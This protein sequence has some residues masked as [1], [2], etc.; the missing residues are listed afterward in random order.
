MTCNPLAMLDALL[1]DEKHRTSI[2]I[3]LFTH[4]EYEELSEKWKLSKDRIPNRGNMEEYLVDKEG[5]RAFVTPYV[6]MFSPIQMGTYGPASKTQGLASE[7]V[8][9]MA[10]AFVKLNQGHTRKEILETKMKSDLF[11]TNQDMYEIASKF[12]HV[13]WIHAT[14]KDNLYDIV[15]SGVL[16]C[17]LA[18]KDYR[19]PR[20]TQMQGVE[21]SIAYANGEEPPFKHTKFIHF[22]LDIPSLM[23]SDLFEN[24]SLRVIMNE[25]DAMTIYGS[26]PLKY[27]NIIDVEYKCELA[28]INPDVCT[29]D[30]PCTR[31]IAQ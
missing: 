26:V 28:P 9:L 27:F 2:V 20:P 17:M 31:L 13:W 16:D 19:E 15:K 11:L 23:E 10:I 3:I 25:T 18:K 24:G 6:S 4:S 30:K 8:D 5:R 14:Y 21:Y 22:I 1:L 29:M 7:G 12:P